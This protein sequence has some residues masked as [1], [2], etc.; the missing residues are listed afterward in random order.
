MQPV[1][2][3]APR[4]PSDPTPATCSDRPSAFSGLHNKELQLTRPGSRVY[5]ETHVS[6]ILAHD[7]LLS[8]AALPSVPRSSERNLRSREAEPVVP[9]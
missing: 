9:S 2:I 3:D 1:G 7:R 6:G 5:I 4:G 8:L